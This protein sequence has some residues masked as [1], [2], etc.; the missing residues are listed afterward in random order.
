MRQVPG[1]GAVDPLLSSRAAQDAIERV[2]K[3]SQAALRAAKQEYSAKLSKMQTEHTLKLLAMTHTN[4]DA[5][6]APDTTDRVAELED[7]L[8]I[9]EQT[10]NERIA[11]LEEK[12]RV[13]RHALEAG[14]EQRV[15][16][17]QEA[18]RVTLLGMQERYEA[19]LSEVRETLAGCV[20]AK[21]SEYKSIINTQ[22]HR[23]EQTDADLAQLKDA[24]KVQL[25]TLRAEHAAEAARMTDSNTAAVD[26]IR[27][28][29]EERISV[30]ATSFEERMSAQSKAAAEQLEHTVSAHEAR[31][32]N[33]TAVYKEKLETQ[34][35]LYDDRIQTI[36]ES[37]ASELQK[38][39]A[40][41]TAKTQAVCDELAAAQIA[42]EKREQMFTTDIADLT[43][44]L[45]AAEADDLVSRAKAAD[46]L[47][48]DLAAERS[49][50]S[51]H[52][53]QLVTA[54]MAL[55]SVHSMLTGCDGLIDAGDVVKAKG[56]VGA[57]VT[58]LE[59]FDLDAEITAGPGCPTI[60]A[61]D[62]QLRIG[63]GGR[64]IEAGGMV[65]ADPGLLARNTQL[66]ADVIAFEEQRD[67]LVTAINEVRG[68]RDEA[69]TRCDALQARIGEITA[70]E[71]D[72]A[73]L[74]HIR[75]SLGD[76]IA[77]RDA[78]QAQLDAVTKAS[79][80]DRAAGTK[81]RR[82]L[83]AARDELVRANRCLTDELAQTRS[84][85]E[86]LEAVAT[87]AGTDEVRVE[88][89]EA[90]IEEQ[91]VELGAVGEMLE[92]AKTE[93]S[94][95]A[96]KYERGRATDKEIQRLT[97]QNK[98]MMTRLN[99]NKM[100]TTKMQA[101]IKAA[102]TAAEEAAKRAAAADRK[103]LAASA[104]MKSTEEAA[105]SQQRKLITVN[106]DLH[107]LCG[108]VG[109]RRAD[110]LDAVKGLVAQ[111]QTQA[112]R[113]DKLSGTITE[114]AEANRELKEQVAALDQERADLKA[115]ITADAKRMMELHAGLRAA[116][117]TSTHHASGYSPRVNRARRT[118]I[119]AP[120]ANLGRMQP[121]ELDS[122]TDLQ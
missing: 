97:L 64:T 37:S 105:T 84:T 110:L 6:S 43:E 106:Q 19:E 18:S 52:A 39:L 32:A 116:R 91:R 121:N 80:T 49:T 8:R 117:E 70:K 3:N 66:E 62:G 78:L 48:E 79:K 12:L 68:Q 28:S 94:A 81:A 38:Q 119:G 113:G 85:V 4:V 9:Q 47:E 29:Y 108:V 87:R 17:A 44:R 30:M 24:H 57:A 111:A 88:Q 15:R 96:A 59:G 11:S 22:Q 1:Q 67:D 120:A 41:A 100:E 114:L 10:T 92:H 55:S 51:R 83:E 26:G 101:A 34:Q 98:K 50:S 27:A 42:A 103:A 86:G 115:Q 23:I 82:Q 95:L 53:R 56:H 112:G 35:S 46:A 61:L 5:E 58:L 72:L 2:E 73:K 118:P 36:T 13:A 21:D 54:A 74:G 93:Y 122:W 104:A 40:E 60:T 71:E 76:A 77:E 65:L 69:C 7:Q 14:P 25:D 107:S 20:A 33:A 90:V 63:E 75:R 45:A 89:L 109:A 31:I 16:A 102:E 99:L